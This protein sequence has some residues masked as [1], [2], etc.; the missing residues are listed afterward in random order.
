MSSQNKLAR[1]RWGAASLLPETTETNKPAT[2]DNAT[3]IVATA[4]ARSKNA[5]FVFRFRNLTPL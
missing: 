1:Q 5:T 4:N 2:K 3:D